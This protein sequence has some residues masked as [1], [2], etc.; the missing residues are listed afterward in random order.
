MK[1]CYPN[2][3]KAIKDKN[4][5]NDKA[6]IDDP[7][8]EGKKSYG[9]VLDD[10]REEFDYTVDYRMNHIPLNFE[11]N[12]MLIDP[13]DYRL[14]VIDAYVTETGSTQRLTDFTIRKVNETDSVTKKE[15]TVVVADIPQK[16]G[17]KT[18]SVDEGNYGG[19]KFKNTHYM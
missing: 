1:Y 18:D 6:D 12:A 2:V 7:V 10:V 9:A 15:R 19:H 8:L 13:I 16:P 11:K 3:K 14:D 5:T 17:T 4:T